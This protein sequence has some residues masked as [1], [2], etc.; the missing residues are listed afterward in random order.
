MIAFGN[1]FNHLVHTCAPL[2]LF[3]LCWMFCVHTI[4]FHYHTNEEKWIFNKLFLFI[5]TIAEV[6]FVFVLLLFFSLFSFLQFRIISF[7]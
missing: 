6:C 4:A 7:H 2:L 1:G 3:I 5:S